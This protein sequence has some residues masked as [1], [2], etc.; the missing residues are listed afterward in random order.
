MTKGKAS[1]WITKNEMTTYSC[2]H[3]LF[4]GCKN[5]FGFQCFIKLMSSTVGF[6]SFLKYQPQL[7]APDKHFLNIKK[8]NI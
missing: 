6:P 4:V 8:N 7:E 5:T 2:F 3:F 1:G